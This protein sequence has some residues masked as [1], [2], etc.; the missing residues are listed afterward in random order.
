MFSNQI[1]TVYEEVDP[2]SPSFRYVC[3]PLQSVFIRIRI[4]CGHTHSQTSS[5]M[6]TNQC[7][8]PFIPL[9]SVVFGCCGAFAVAGGNWQVEE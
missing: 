8:L 2:L 3:I 9:P 7:S 5:E 6:N 1:R 4:V